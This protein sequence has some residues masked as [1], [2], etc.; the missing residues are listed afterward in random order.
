MI[1]PALSARV[2]AVFADLNGADQPGGVL[3][4]IDQDQIVY[5]RG[6]GLAN[7]ETKTPNTPDSVFYLA[8]LSK[9][10][11]AMAIMLLAER[12]QLRYDDPLLTYVPQFSAWGAEITLRH[13]LNHISGLPDYIALF[14]TQVYGENIREYTREITG[15]TNAAAVQRVLSEAGLKFP[16]GQQY[17]YSNTNYVLLALIV[18]AVS[19]QSFAD[20]LRENIFDPLGMQHTFVYDTSRPEIPNLAQGYLLEEGRFERWDYPLLT[21]GD[22]GIFST[23]NDLFRWDQALN[24]EHLVP[25]PT[26]ERAF[27]S[28]TSNDG[29]P[30]GY[31]FGWMTAVFPGLR[32]VAHGGSLCAYN[33]YLIRFL[34]S[35]R[36]IIVLTNHRWAPGPRLRAHQVAEILFGYVE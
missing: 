11:T 3:L 13:L 35:Q 8:S 16:V 23:L 27:T 21:A 33:N 36:T 34:D 28:G 7:L 20:F 5:S 30:V 1:D 9:Q 24:S 15:I 18:E 6:Y 19:S 26:L 25:K 14:T 29:K 10:F 12:Q 32:H 31:G 17:Q 22:G 4:I 2:D